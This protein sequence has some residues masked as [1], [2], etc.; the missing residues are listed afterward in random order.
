MN[1]TPPPSV[2]LTKF[3]YFLIIDGTLWQAHTFAKAHAFT[4]LATILYFDDDKNSTFLALTYF[5]IDFCI[6]TFYL[7]TIL[8]YDNLKANFNFDE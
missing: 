3:T 1:N 5:S 4:D 6:L 7:L 8:P 2:W